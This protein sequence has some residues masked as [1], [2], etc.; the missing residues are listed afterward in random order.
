MKKYRVLI[1]GKNFLVKIESK[2]ELHGFFTTRFIEARHETE[3]E[4][5]ALDLIRDELKDVVLNERSD[6]PMMYIDK[7][8]ELI[9]FGDN[10]VP[11]AGFTW[12]LEET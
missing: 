9:S 11:G 12:F 2:I 8:D 7:I 5:I 4:K 6:P 1:E 10:L 3:A